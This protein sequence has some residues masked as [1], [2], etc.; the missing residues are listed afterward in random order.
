MK[1]SIERYMNRIINAKDKPKRPLKSH[2]NIA[3]KPHP[4]KKSTK[5]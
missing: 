4:S 2:K 1:L 5:N 3:K